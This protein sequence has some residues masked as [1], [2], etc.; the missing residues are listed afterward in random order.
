[1]TRRGAIGPLTLGALLAL[2]S[3]AHVAALSWRALGGASREAFPPARLLDL[4]LSH[5]GLALAGLLPAALVGIG[6]GVAV[7]R[8]EGGALR[9]LVDR[10]AAAAQ[11]VPPVV[12]VALSFPA[13]GFGPAP[14]MLALFLYSLMP[15]LRGT[16]AALEAAPPDAKAA[17]QAIGLT[18]A[19]TLREVELPLAWPVI[20]QA[21]RIAL[22]LAI[23]TAAVGALAGAATLGTPIILGLQNQNELYILQGA[24]ATAALAF[25][26][27]GIVQ[28]AAASAGRIADPRLEGLRLDLDAGLVGEVKG[29]APVERS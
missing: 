6:L 7:T 27:D 13:L 9:P 24:A 12:V 23:A 17:A 4:S 2:L 20:L 10:I 25:L 16:V 11:A 21:L 15:I 1:M 14:T 28:L 8:P 29:L 3:E 18:P 5:A 19:Q 22:V 26:A